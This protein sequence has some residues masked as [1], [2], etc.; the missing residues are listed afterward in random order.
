[1]VCKILDGRENLEDDEINGQPTA[2]RTQD[3][4]ETVC[5]LISTDRLMTLGMMEAEILS[6]LVQ[7]SYGVRPQFQE[8]GSWF[9]LHDNVRPHTALS[10]KQFLEKQGIP[11]LN[12]PLYSSDLS[13]PDLFLFPKFKSTLFPPSVEGGKTPTHLVPLERDCFLNVVFSSV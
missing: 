12:L 6:R 7:R 8:R 1:M 11:E 9:R 4:I 10:V 13:P 2:V 3:M 5:E